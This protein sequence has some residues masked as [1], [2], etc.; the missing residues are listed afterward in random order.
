MKWDATADQKLLLA[1]I[2][3]HHI[4]L[5]S[6]RVSTILG[7]TPGA[8]EQRLWKLRKMAKESWGMD[9]SPSPAT[10]TKKPRRKKVTKNNNNNNTVHSEENYFNADDDEFAVKAEE[11][12]SGSAQKRRKSV[13]AAP[14]YHRTLAGVKLPLGVP[15]EVS[16]TPVVQMDG[17]S[18]MEDYQH[19]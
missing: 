1:V 4:V 19:M 2:S 16:E 10:P 7:C 12:E 3:M 6:Q 14:V 13:A 9:M 5:D 8:C 11:S 17:S 18:T 15:L